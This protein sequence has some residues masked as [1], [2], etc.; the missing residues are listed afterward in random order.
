MYFIYRDGRYIDVAG[1]SFKD[2]L[3]GRL[4]E[5]P[6]ERPTLADWSDHLTTLF[7]EVRMKQ[8]LEMRG[9]DGGRWRRICAVAAFWTGLLYDH[10]SLDAAWDLVKAWTAAERQALRDL[11][12][13]LALQAP[14]HGTTALEVARQAT[15]IAHAGLTRRAYRQPQRTGRDPLSRAG[16][17]HCA[18]GL[19]A[20]RRD[21]AA[22]R[23]CL[24]P[25]HRS[26]VY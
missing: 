19:H 4:S 15:A 2:F 10:S 9:A 26:T 7:P 23:N 14:V 8:F 25:E 13:K 6:G 22:L 17:G 18:A 20:R 21:A 3:D 16:R 24:G 11:V 5:L 12:P 1:A